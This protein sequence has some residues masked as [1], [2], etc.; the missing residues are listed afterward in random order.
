[1]TFYLIRTVTDGVTL[2]WNS[3]KWVDKR[4]EAKEYSEID[5]LFEGMCAATP[6]WQM[7]QVTKGKE[8]IGFNFPS[9]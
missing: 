5:E 7:V 1:M 2:W 9:R 8:K 3:Y 6:P 4:E